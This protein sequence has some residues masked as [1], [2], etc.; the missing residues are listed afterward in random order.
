MK[1]Q[2][3]ARA[4]VK[5]RGLALLLVL[6]AVMTG[7]TTF[8]SMQSTRIK[9][10]PEQLRAMQLEHA[11]FKEAS[12]SVTG[13]ATARQEYTATTDVAAFDNMMLFGLMQRFP[14]LAKSQGLRLSIV[15]QAR[16]LVHLAKGETKCTG[17]SCRTRVEVVATLLGDGRLP[18]WE[19]R[20]TLGPAATR[21]KIE[22]DW[23]GVFAD[24]LLQAMKR[25][26]V[27]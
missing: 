9:G 23:F 12:R 27:I 22:E 24:Q 11:S 3:G 19:F 26:G 21:P 7:C 2:T 13:R 5:Q 15:A 18:S 20:T 1:A 10:E 25:D 4:A 14:A 16:L 8:P 17:S 6:L